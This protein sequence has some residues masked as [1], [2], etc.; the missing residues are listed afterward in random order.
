M[1]IPLLTQAV[2]MGLQ[3]A[4]DNSRDNSV[5]HVTDLAV[6]IGEGC[7]RQLWLKLKGADK[8][9][10]S[11]GM[12]LMYRN[13]KRIH[14]DLVCLLQNGLP[15]EWEI[16][17]VEVPME[18]DEI[19]GT[20][21]ILLKNTLTHEIIVADFKTIRGKG[22]Y[23]LKNGAKPA[24]R[25]QVQTYCYGL[26]VSRQYDADAG[27]VLY[28]D[29]EG[30]NAFQQF[31]VERD[32][33]AVKD[34]IVEVKLIRDASK[35]PDIL[36]PIA[37]EGRATLTKGVP[38]YVSMPWMCSYCDYIDVSCPSALPKNVREM[39]VVGHITTDAFT[40]TKDLTAEVFSSII[41]QLVIPF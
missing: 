7:P 13:G 21:D 17:G 28:V 39:G 34:A 23:F 2:E 15:S 26:D 11:A 1:R 12:M 18:F 25:L 19:H 20:A 6:T 32:D 24:N 33:N 31:L 30:Q 8:R 40:P 4:E 9:K 38:V 10:L 22:F 41:D 29:R 27:L 36:P 16:I 14:E 35:A 5:L 3:L 37:T